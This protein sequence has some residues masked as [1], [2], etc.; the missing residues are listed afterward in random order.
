MEKEWYEEE[1]QPCLKTD[2]KPI[3]ILSKKE[4]VGHVIKLR[5]HKVVCVLNF[6]WRLGYC[7][8]QSIYNT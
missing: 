6:N 4:S 8:G 5:P 3:I 2:N 7:L 1:V